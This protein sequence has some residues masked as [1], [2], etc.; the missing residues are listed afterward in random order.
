MLRRN[1]PERGMIDDLERRREQDGN[2]GKFGTWQVVVSAWAVV[3]VFI[4]LLAG[5]K[6]VAHLHGSSHPHR[7]LAG[8]VIPQH[9]ACSGPGIASAPGVDGCESI[10]PGPDRSA[11]W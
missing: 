1:K 7:H 2:D 8:V 5:A 4:I 3:L 6:A 11:Y 9:G 10:P